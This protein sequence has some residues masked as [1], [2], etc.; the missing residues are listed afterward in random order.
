MSGGPPN[1]TVGWLLVLLAGVIE[2][3]WA[4]GLRYASGVWSWL[5]VAIGYVACLPLLTLAYRHLPAGTAY[6]VWVGIG[7]LGVCVWGILMLGESASLLRI[8]CLLLI[9]VGII[10]LKL[11][12]A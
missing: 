7:S 10:G 9:F 1:P 8:L 5:A 3:G 12:P 11:L 6:S 4:V 2:M